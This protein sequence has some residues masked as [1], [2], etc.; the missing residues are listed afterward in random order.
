MTLLGA[1]VNGAGP[2]GPG[3]SQLRPSAAIKYR[4]FNVVM[5]GKRRLP[6]FTTVNIDGAHVVRSTGKTTQV[7]RRR[8]P[9]R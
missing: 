3:R 7:H 6:Y 1:G 2:V 4:H 5:N 8:S 9:H